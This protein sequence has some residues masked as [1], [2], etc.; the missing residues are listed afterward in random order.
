MTTSRRG[1][2]ILVPF[3]NSDLKTFK[4]RPALVVQDET[5]PTGLPQK[6]VVPITSN[7]NRKGP[8][9]LPIDASS[10]EGHQMGL[11]TDSVIVTDNMATMP[12]YA[13]L[14]T[15]GTCPLMHDVGLMLKKTLGLT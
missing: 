15:I 14:K 4:S 9:R 8:T 2:V 10:P 6:V 5:V 3:P 13:I 11:E 1:D 12:D 7:K